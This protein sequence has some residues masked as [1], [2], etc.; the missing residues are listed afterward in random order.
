MAPPNETSCHRL[1]KLA[2][3]VS[4]AFVIELACLFALAR[5]VADEH[6]G[7][8][9]TATYHWG[10]EALKDLGGPEEKP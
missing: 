8:L 5:A 3:S 7:E 2:W 4:V 1:G 9:I 10:I 6:C